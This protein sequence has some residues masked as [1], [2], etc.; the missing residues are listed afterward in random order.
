MYISTLFFI[1]FVG[2]KIIL[3]IWCEYLRHRQ[4]IRKEYDEMPQILKD[5][6]NDDQYNRSQSYTTNY[7][8]FMR[9]YDFISLISQIGFF[10]CNALPAG[11]NLTEDF[12]D[13]IYLDSNNEVKIM[14]TYS[15][16]EVQFS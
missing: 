5:R 12:L 6:I 11:W 13:I 3:W 16:T 9:Y 14:I 1:M 10:A 2:T 8:Y 4:L 15:I 7:L